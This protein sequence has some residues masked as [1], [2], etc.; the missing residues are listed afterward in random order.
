MLT[1][2]APAL[3]TMTETIFQAAGAPP[4]I[5]TAV[6]E[7]LSLANL[8]GHDSHGVMRIPA[9]VRSIQAGHVKPAAEPT[10]ARQKG[11]SALI[12]GQHGFG[13]I[14]GRFATERAVALAKEYG[15]A[16]VGVF[17]CNHV[18]RL[19]EYPER[20]AGEGV[21]LL[22]TCGSIGNPRSSTAPFGGRTGILGTNPFAIGMP[23]GERPPMI[24]DFA[25]TVVAGGKVEVARAKGVELPPGAIL[26]KHGRPSVNPNDV[27]DGGTMLTFGGHKG[28][29]LAMAASVLSQ[30]LTGETPVGGGPG[31]M[32][33]FL[34]AVD[35]GAFVPAADVAR[36][37]DW[38]IDTVTAVPPA[39][40]VE[41]VLVPGDP[42]R[43]ESE[44]RLANGVPVPEKTWEAIQKTAEALGV[45]DS[46]PAATA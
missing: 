23:A 26:D 17:N 31:K 39:A 21:L 15:A 11:A 24:V 37:V 30:A 19:G 33:F 4:H 41:R 13:Q 6:A 43:A 40:G 38:M 28:F 25:T 27:A 35:T 22:V 42:E 12:D 10:I 44:R 7:A 2:P 36:R 34:W 45:A 3:R 46:L 1:F 18:G 29:G 5:A 20:A 8:K 14:A 16:A 9:Y 32:G